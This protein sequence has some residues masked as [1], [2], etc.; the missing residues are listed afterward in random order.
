MNFTQEKPAGIEV[1]MDFLMALRWVE[2]DQELLAE[3]SQIFL[4]DRPR[5]LHEL[6]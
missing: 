6:E 2:G 1:P 4:E 5:K 3:L